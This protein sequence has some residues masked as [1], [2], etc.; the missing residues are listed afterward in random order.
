MNV[1]PNFPS[2]VGVG[3]GALWAVNGT[4]QSF[5]VALKTLEVCALPSNVNSNVNKR[6]ER[7][8]PLV[9]SVLKSHLKRVTIPDAVLTQFVLLKMSITV[10]ETCRGTYLV[11][12]C[13]TK[14][15]DT[16]IYTGESCLDLTSYHTP[17]LITMFAH[18]P[19]KSK[20]PYTATR[21]TGIVLE[22]LSVN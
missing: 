1:K 16:N 5:G 4:V 11:D 19:G 6:A 18:I 2:F 9:I 20:K 22:K 15:T 3:N 7:P 13:V 8:C 12:F 10:L 17:I 21:P 14:G